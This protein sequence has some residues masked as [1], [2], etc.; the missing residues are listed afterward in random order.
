MSAEVKGGSGLVEEVLATVEA[1][2]TC[3]PIR[4]QRLQFR[5]HGVGFGLLIC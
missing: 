3:R 1:T 5:A 4:A 2:P